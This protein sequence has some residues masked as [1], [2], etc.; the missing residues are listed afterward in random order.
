MPIAIAL[1]AGGLAAVNPCGFPLLPVF[2]SYFIGAD[3]QSLPAARSRPAQGL[4]VGASVAGGFL[5]VFALVGIPISY[6]ATRLTSAVPW[7]GLAVGVAMMAVGSL[8]LAGR[9]LSPNLRGV[10]GRQGR[11]VRTM[12][13][14]GA[15]YAVCSLGCTL[16]LFLALIG[17]SLAASRLAEALTVLGAYGLGMATTLMA[18]AVGAALARDGLARALKRLLPHMHRI[19]GGLLL[20]SGAYLSYYWARVLWAPPDALARDALVGAVSDFAS[21]IQRSAGSDGGRLLILGAGTVV[22]IAMAAALWRASG[23]SGRPEP[24]QAQA[25]VPDES[26]PRPAPRE[27]G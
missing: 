14:F 13:T 15:A 9:T 26:S 4:L 16:P 7:A 17:A 3:E 11:G 20:T 8:T 6:G 10:R 22:A 2:L 1:V 5:G 27:A 25:P 24:P 12:V 21:W 18:L 23:R 19:A